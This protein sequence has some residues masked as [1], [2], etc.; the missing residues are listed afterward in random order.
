MQSKCARDLSDL[1]RAPAMRMNERVDR[2]TVGLGG[3]SERGSL[4]VL[5]PPSLLCELFHR[6]P[7]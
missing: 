2:G 5:A 1:E 4:V 3:Q 7:E 6:L